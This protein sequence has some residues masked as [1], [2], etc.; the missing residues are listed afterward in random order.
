[1]YVCMYVCMYVRFYARLCLNG[2]DQNLNSCYLHVINC[3]HVRMYTYIHTYKKYPCIVHR[4]REASLR[5]RMCVTSVPFTITSSTHL[6]IRSHKIFTHRTQKACEKEW[7][8]GKKGHLLRTANLMH[9]CTHTY[10]YIHVY[11]HRRGEI[12]VQAKTKWRK[13]AHSL[14]TGNFWT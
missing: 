5:A 4:R 6:V 3:I 9:A 10:K 12:T 8:D 7:S 1:M 13:C 11:I 2:T 14:R